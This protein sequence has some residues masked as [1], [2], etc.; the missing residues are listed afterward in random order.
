VSLASLDAAIAEGDRLL[1]DTTTLAAYLD[2]TDAT[3]PVAR[4]VLQELVATGRNP[5]VVSMIS[6]MEILVRPL[7]SS[8]PAHHTVLSFLRTH[9]HLECV[10][11]DMQVARE[12]AHLRASERFSPSD[13]LIVGTGLA[14]QVHHLFTNDGEWARKLV[15]MTGRIAVVRASE[16]LPFP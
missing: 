3:H 13:A 16:H 11:I 1:L 8:P 7:R 14:T 12:A 2:A 6:V 9:P 10:A 4:H 15:R 5:A